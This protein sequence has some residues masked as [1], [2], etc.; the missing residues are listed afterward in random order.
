[1]RHHPIVVVGRKKRSG[2]L[3]RFVELTRQLA[4]TLQWKNVSGGILKKLPR[5]AARDEKN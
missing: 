2:P 5:Q 3:R 1:M 4:E